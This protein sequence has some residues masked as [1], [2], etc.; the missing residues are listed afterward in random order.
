MDDA[1]R[2]ELIVSDQG[3][4]M[5][6][7]EIRDAFEPFYRAESGNIQSTRG[8]GLGL[9]Y[10]KYAVEKMNG[11][12]RIKSELNKGTQVHIVWKK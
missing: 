11:E 7:P 4:G 9:N 5:S 3:I 1:D 2:T 6:K 10:V 8:F 12:I